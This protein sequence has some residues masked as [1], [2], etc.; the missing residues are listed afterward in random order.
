MKGFKGRKVK[1][2][3]RDTDLFDQKYDQIVPVDAIANHERRAFIVGDWGSGKTALV[4]E[5]HKYYKRGLLLD[6]YTIK[7]DIKLDEYIYSIVES[8]PIIE[9]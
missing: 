6:L 2:V 9:D 5:L 3:G 7:T 8:V 4:K 1:F